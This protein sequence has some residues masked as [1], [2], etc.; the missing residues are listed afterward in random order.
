MRIYFQKAPLRRSWV[1]TSSLG[2]PFPSP[3]Q[4]PSGRHTGSGDSPPNGGTEDPSALPRQTPVPCR[5]IR[6]IPPA[7]EPLIETLPP[8]WNHALLQ[9]LGVTRVLPP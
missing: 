9:G 5:V 3:A 4:D 7:Q 2:R 8:I 6:D 1:H